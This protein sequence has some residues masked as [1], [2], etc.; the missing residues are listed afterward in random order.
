MRRRRHPILAVL[1][2]ALISLSLAAC[3]NG[4]ESGGGTE[5]VLAQ[6][7]WEDLMVENQI[8]KSVLEDL[9]HSVTIQDLSV[10]VAANGMSGGQIDVYLGNWWPSQKDVFQKHIDSGDIEVLDT[11]VEGVAYE[12]AVPSYVA[13]EHGVRSLADLDEQREAFG[14]EILGIEP[15]TPG[16]ESISNAIDSDAYGLGDWKLVESST[17][18]MLSEVERRTKKDEPVVFLAWDPH[19][20]NVKWDLVYLEDPDGAWPG[21]GE[22]RIAARSGFAAENPDIARFLSQME[23]D[24]STASEWI[25]QVG[26]EGDSPEAVARDW[27]SNNQD[28][29]DEWLRGVKSASGEEAASRT[30]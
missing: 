22:I 11:L 14:G 30:R 20:M 9:G 25:H 17:P 5:V 2:A 3:G 19:W 1:S 23:V 15:G 27:L 6:Q 7:P 10:P 13:E 21:A 4:Q 18:A 8:V 28:Q 24:K 12:P 16:N 26:Q 29:V